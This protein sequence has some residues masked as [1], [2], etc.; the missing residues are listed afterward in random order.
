MTLTEAMMELHFLR[1]VYPEDFPQGSSTPRHIWQPT[2]H[3]VL[4][5][6]QPSSMNRI[7][8][9]VLAMYKEGRLGFHLQTALSQSALNTTKKKL[10]TDPLH[11]KAIAA[12]GIQ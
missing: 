11:Y 7:G 9:R 1:Q 10:H 5:L 4:P 2:S 6:S 8:D 12:G 3:L